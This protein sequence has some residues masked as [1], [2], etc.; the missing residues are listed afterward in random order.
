M[1]AEG[2]ANLIIILIFL[3]SGVVRNFMGN[4]GQ[5]KQP[6]QVPG[7]RPAPQR[8]APR[9][10]VQQA[11]QPAPPRQQSPTSQKRQ[12]GPPR[13]SSAQPS[14]SPYLSALL[15]RLDE[16]QA[17]VDALKASNT[18]SLLSDKRYSAIA[19]RLVEAV[20]EP[21]RDVTELIAKIRAEVQAG[22]ANQ[23]TLS[24]PL[25]QIDDL[26]AWARAKKSVLETLE[27]QRRPG[28]LRTRLEALDGLS[29]ALISG[30]TDGTDRPRVVV[31]HDGD[32]D[33]PSTIVGDGPVGLVAIRPFEAK[34]V[35][36]AAALLRGIAFDAL[37]CFPNSHSAIRSGIMS[38]PLE[39]RAAQAPYYAG[40]NYDPVNSIGC[41]APGLAADMV[42]SFLGGAEYAKG[43]IESAWRSGV[44]GRQ[45]VSIS[46]NRGFYYYEAPLAVR[47]AAIDSVLHGDD[48]EGKFSALEAMQERLS[49]PNEMLYYSPNGQARRL[50][51]EPMF[52]LIRAICS[53][54]FETRLDGLNQRSLGQILRGSLGGA[55]VSIA[56]TKA[57]FLRGEIPTGQPAVLW[58]GAIEAEVSVGDGKTSMMD[59]LVTA[60][61][62]GGTR[63]SASARTSTARGR[64]VDS[65]SLFRDAYVLSEIL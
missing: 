23:Y 22:R 21:I 52:K 4:K 61:T 58:A 8:P 14:Q 57:E 26:L 25:K 49:T 63:R 62:G 18:T 6:R 45:A 48:P 3:L 36:G 24:G 43:V 19:R 33:L 5:G 60:L 15:A 16:K 13:T 41:W 65:R 27:K 55:A 50:K 2:I 35:A 20:G 51:P 47:M 7:Q 54:L 12:P 64:S 44:T 40:P 29:K 38:G 39:G 11:P 10:P 1:D 30:G 37:A 42:A 53:T 9:G 59:R 32:P 34:S 46:N 56:S 17:T 31:L 28:H